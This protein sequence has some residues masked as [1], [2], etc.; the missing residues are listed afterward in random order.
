[1]KKKIKGTDEKM[2]NMP[3]L[4]A[5]LLVS[6]LL[7][8]VVSIATAFFFEYL[9][10]PHHRIEDADYFHATR[11]NRPA[12][13]LELLPHCQTAQSRSAAGKSEGPSMHRLDLK[14]AQEV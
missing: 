9:R 6:A 1:M 12:L 13:P 2:I 14:P 11:G 8:P 5:L 3:E 7:L 10:D 4:Y